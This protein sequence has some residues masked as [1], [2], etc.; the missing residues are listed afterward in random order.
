MDRVF[1]EFSVYAVSHRHKTSVTL[2]VADGKEIQLAPLIG[3]DTTQYHASLLI[4][5]A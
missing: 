2:V 5:K 4:G 1:T 3:D